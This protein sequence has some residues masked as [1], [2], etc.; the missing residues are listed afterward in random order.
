MCTQPFGVSLG[1]NYTE[2]VYRGL[3]EVGYS[4]NSRKLLQA[5]GEDVAGIVENALTRFVDDSCRQA[6]RVSH[7]VKLAIPIFSTYTSV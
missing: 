2:I 1:V 6:A 4:F 7:L 5:S 3:I